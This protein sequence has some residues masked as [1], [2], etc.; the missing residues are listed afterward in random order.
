AGRLASGDTAFDVARA[1][2]AATS[3]GQPTRPADLLLNGL[4]TRFT[5]GYAAGKE[6]LQ[7]AVRAFAAEDLPP[8]EEIRWLWLACVCAAELWDDES[9]YSLSS[10]YVA[11][12][13]K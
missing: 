9:W 11:R 4:A 1:A 7:R 13:R 10:R 3:A 12:A 5:S 6:P 2:R 8:E